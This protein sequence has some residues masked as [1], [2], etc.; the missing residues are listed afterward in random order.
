MIGS[1]I[2]ITLRYCGYFSMEIVNSRSINFV[3]TILKIRPQLMSFTSIYYPIDQFQWYGVPNPSESSG[4][5]TFLFLCQI[6]NK[7][8]I[9]GGT[10]DKS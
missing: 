2:R 10:I 6:N 3:E 4:V 7:L 1:D 5:N 9:S 8:C